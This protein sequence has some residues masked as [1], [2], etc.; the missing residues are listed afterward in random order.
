[1]S[2]EVM[3]HWHKLKERCQK[4]RR[5]AQN[6]LVVSTGPTTGRFCSR[7]CYEAARKEME[8]HER[9]QNSETVRSG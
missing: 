4:C 3:G 5:V 9:A 6:L 1:M 2:E 7:F 8:E